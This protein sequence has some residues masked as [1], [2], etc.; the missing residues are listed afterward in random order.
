MSLLSSS[1]PWS[2]SLWEEVAPNFSFDLVWG[3]SLVRSLSLPGVC[4]RL[5]QHRA[6][7]EIL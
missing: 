3:G 2:G 5:G 4:P 1:A 6:E 7:A